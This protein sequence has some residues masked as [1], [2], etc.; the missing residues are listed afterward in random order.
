VLSIKKN[1]PEYGR[2][3]FYYNK[4]TVFVKADCKAA[5]VIGH[6]D[7]MGNPMGGPL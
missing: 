3:L 6:S 2:F 4:L 5:L 7:I 1:R